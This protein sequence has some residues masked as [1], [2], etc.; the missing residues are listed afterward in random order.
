[1]TFDARPDR[2]FVASAG[3]DATSGGGGITFNVV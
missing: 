3:G 2:V 1:M